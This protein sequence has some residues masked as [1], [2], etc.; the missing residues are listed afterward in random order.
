MALV[1]ATHTFANVT[2]DSSELNTYVRDPISF[3]LNPPR[4]ELLRAASQ[5]I[6]N[7]T[8]TAISFD[9]EVVDKNPDGSKNHSNSVN[10]SRFTAVYAGLY[11]ASG[12]VGWLANAT[13]RRGCWLAV[14]GT[15][16]TGTAG[17]IYAGALAVAS[18]LRT[19]QVYL[20]VGDYLEL[21]AYQESTIALG[22][23]PTDIYQPNLTVRWVANA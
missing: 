5:S 18:V 23:E 9:T 12:G 11:Q 21:L 6:N 13:G 16:V 7:A 3:L 19:K 4:A 1:P 10:P 20:N 8:A 17:I 14:N 2:L 22:T 15:V